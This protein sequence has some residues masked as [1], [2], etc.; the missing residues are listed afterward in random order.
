[1]SINARDAYL[2]GEFES[3][4][5]TLDS[6]QKAVT[7]YQ[8][9]ISA[10]PEY[11]EAYA[12]LGDAYVLL[13]GYGGLAAGTAFARAQDAARTENVV[14]RPVG[15]HRSAHSTLNPPSTK[16]LAPVM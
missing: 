10:D 5:R 7:Y 6:M 11:A 2:H 9:A 4:K 14:L 8:Q 15:F 16:R 1:M 3:S 13:S 12:A